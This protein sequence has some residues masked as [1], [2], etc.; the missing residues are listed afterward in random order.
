[1]SEIRYYA[2][3]EEDFEGM[4]RDQVE[5][6]TLPEYEI[7]DAFEEVITETYGDISI[8][9]GVFEAGAIMR[10]MDPTTFRVGVSDY[11]TEVDLDDYPEEDEDGEN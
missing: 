1:M 2:G 6:L 7:E 4:T 5:A 3:D 10:E 8:G 11:F 9:Y